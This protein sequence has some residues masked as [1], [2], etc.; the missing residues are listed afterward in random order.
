MTQTMSL[1]E[2]QIVPRPTGDGLKVWSEPRMR[3]RWYEEPE[4]K[5]Q[6]ELRQYG[7]WWLAQYDDST[8]CTAECPWRAAEMAVA[9]AKERA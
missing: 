9:R 5:G 8:E 1:F 4:C 7:I 2:Q 3:W 6:N